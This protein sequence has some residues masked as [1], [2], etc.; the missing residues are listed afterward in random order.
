MILETVKFLHNY[1]YAFS[2]FNDNAYK[3]LQTRNICNCYSCPDEFL[4]TKWTN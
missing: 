2:I 3:E 4:S 1:N